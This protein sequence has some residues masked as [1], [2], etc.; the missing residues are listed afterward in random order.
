MSDW[1]TEYAE[2][3]WQT[4]AFKNAKDLEACLRWFASRMPK[5]TAEER[6]RRIHWQGIAY[7]GMRVIDKVLANRIT[8]GEGTTE[9]SMQVNA[10]MAMDK[11]TFLFNENKAALADTAT[12][13][14]LLREACETPGMTLPMNWFNRVKAALEGKQ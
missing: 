6:Q 1:I 5:N 3:E 2:K 9:E 7:L 10:R 14:G 11:Y 8:L 4:A 13:R 12:L